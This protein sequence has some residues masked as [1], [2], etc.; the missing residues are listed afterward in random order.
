MCQRLY[1]A[2][3]LE[4]ERKVSLDYFT[5]LTISS[6]FSLTANS[7]KLFLLVIKLLILFYIYEGAFG[8]ST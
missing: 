5:A 6:R 4:I 3:C 1:Y 8:F 2:D 7:L